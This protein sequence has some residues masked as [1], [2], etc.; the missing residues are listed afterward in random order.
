MDHSSLS[1][2]SRLLLGYLIACLNYDDVRAA[3]D[4][5][6]RALA[7]ARDEIAREEGRNHEAGEP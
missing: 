2:R 3:M 4:V 1:V 7:E 5:I 6:D